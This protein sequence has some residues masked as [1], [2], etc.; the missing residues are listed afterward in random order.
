MANEKKERGIQIL[1][2][3][4][5]AIVFLSLVASFYSFILYPSVMP[6]SGPII[7]SDKYRV[8][9]IKKQEIEQRI[10]P[11]IER[12]EFSKVPEKVVPPQRV[13]PPPQKVASPT[14]KVEYSLEIGPIISEANLEEI[15]KGLEGIG[16]K[17]EVSISKE[18][19]DYNR[20]MIGQW[21]KMSGALLVS[22]ELKRKGY[23]PVLM[24]EGEGLYNLA[25]GLFL[26]EK[27][28][29]KAQ[30]KLEGLGYFPTIDKISV[31]QDVYRIK[32]S[33]PSGEGKR[34]KEY[35]EKLQQEGIQS[36]LKEKP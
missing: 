24:K 31:S 11:P 25:V 33:P 26:H 22:K 7:T 36:S 29:Q 18:K 9:E 10:S 4:I 5:F 32:A 3:A 16:I 17:S 15:R 13:A 30:Q 2:W 23:D 21:K 6:K 35:L 12:G 19:V 14:K 1:P 34:A 28:A 20:V 27:N 8:E